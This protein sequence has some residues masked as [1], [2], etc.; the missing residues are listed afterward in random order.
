MTAKNPSRIARL[1]TAAIELEA[2]ERE[3]FLDRE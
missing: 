1:F 2:D 3:A